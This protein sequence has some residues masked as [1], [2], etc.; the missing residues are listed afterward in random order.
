MSAL[1]RTVRAI[2]GALAWP[3]VDGVFVVLLFGCVVAGGWLIARHDRYWDWTRAGANSLRAESV[4]ILRSLEAPLRATVFSAADSP[5]GKAIERLLARYRREPPGLSVRFVDPQRFPEQAR[6]A[7]VSVAGQV[8]LEYRGRRETLEQIGERTLSA[9][10]ARLASPRVPW[11]AVLEGHGER[12]IDGTAPAD[13][14]RFGAELKER[15][16]L[17]RSLD[18]TNAPE[19]P[20]NTDLLVVTTPMIALFPGEAA[21]LAAYLER[22]GN[23]LW[24]I[25]PGPLNGLEVFLDALGIEPLPGTVVDSR[26][27][28][29]ESETAAMAVITAFPQDSPGAGLKAPALL[30]GAVAF[31]DRVGPDWTLEGRLTTGPLSWNETGRIAGNVSRDEVVGEQAGPLPVVLALTRPL[32]GPGRVQRVL[33]A[34]DGDFLS[35]AQIGAFGNREL[36]LAL[37]RWVSAEGGLYALPP[38]PSAPAGLVLD[39]GRRLLLGLGALLILPG[40]FVVCGFTVR[41]LRARG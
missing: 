15:G 27:A 35:N 29:F 6:A 26:A 1:G 19:V 33:V 10:I 4:A 17:V 9:A 8:M 13:L 20:A 38:L 40:F 7:R 23:L 5:Q 21:G 2:L 25:D 37:V 31:A 24:L 34:G 12:R 14:G 36:A 3:A 22:G 32:G 30:P 18:L 41:W 16:F 39:P 11:V 28:Q